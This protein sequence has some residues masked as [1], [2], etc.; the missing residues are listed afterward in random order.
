MSGAAVHAAIRRRAARTGYD[1]DTGAQLGGHSLR[2]EF[3]TQAVSNGTDAHAI[4][5]QTGHTTPGI[6]EFYVRENTSL[7]DNA[8]T[9]LVYDQRR[10]PDKRRDDPDGSRC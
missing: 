3:V 5:H 7:V 2:A 8:V 6:V 4:M 10:G 9:D 1:P